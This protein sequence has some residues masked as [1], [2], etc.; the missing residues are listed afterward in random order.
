ME[1]LPSARPLERPASLRLGFIRYLAVPSILTLTVA[2]YAFSLQAP[3]LGVVPAELLA[4]V[5]ASVVMSLCLVGCEQVAPL[6]HFEESRHQRLTDVIFNIGTATALLGLHPLITG[7]PALWVGLSEAPL[8]VQFVAGW[9]AHDLVLYWWHRALHERGEGLLWRI[10]EVHHQP[11]RMNFMAGGRSHIVEILVTIAALALTKVLLGISAPVM[12][13]LL[14]MPV[15]SGA[16]HHTNADFRM[17][18]LNYLFPGPQMHRAHHDQDPRAALNYATSFPLWDVLFGTAVP[19]RGGHET[20]YGL[21]YT[22]DRQTTWRSAHTITPGA[23]AG[24]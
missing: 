4:F 23:D 11:C 13:W 2:T 21:D 1:S 22:D 9:A 19:L 18:W 7:L 6:E 24:G 17:G 14:M 16:I 5:L 3:A 20:R 15:M 8:V 12:L 10:H